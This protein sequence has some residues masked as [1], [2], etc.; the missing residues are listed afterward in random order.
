[1]FAKIQINLLRN[2]SYNAMRK[3]AQKFTQNPVLEFNNKT[4]GIVMP[5]IPASNQLVNTADTIHFEQP[6]RIVDFMDSMGFSSSE[7][8]N[9]LFENFSE[10]KKQNPYFEELAEEL[11]KIDPKQAQYKQGSLN[12]FLSTS[13]I[14]SIKNK[15][16]QIFKRKIEQADIQKNND[17]NAA[18]EIYAKVRSD[19]SNRK[20]ALT[21]DQ[22]RKRMANFEVA[23]GYILPDY[24]KYDKISSLAADIYD[25]KCKNITAEYDATTK[26]NELN[27]DNKKNEIE[28]FYKQKVKAAEEEYKSS[29]DNEVYILINSKYK[30]LEN[31][32]NIVLSQANTP[33]KFEVALRMLQEN[34]KS[35]TIIYDNDYFETVLPEITKE[36]IGIQ[37]FILDINANKDIESMVGSKTAGIVLKLADTSEKFEIA[38]YMLNINT[39][40][41][42]QLFKDT[43]FAGILPKITKQNKKSAKTILNFIGSLKINTSD[44]LSLY[45]NNF[46]KAKRQN[47]EFNNMLDLMT[48]INSKSRKITADL[49]D[50][51]FKLSTTPEKTK[52]ATEMLLMKPNNS[53]NL[54]AGDDFKN[55]LSKTKTIKQAK[56][57]KSAIKMLSKYYIH[58]EDKTEFVNEF[59]S[60]FP[61]KYK[62]LLGYLPIKIIDREY[63]DHRVMRNSSSYWKDTS[64]RFLDAYYDNTIDYPDYPDIG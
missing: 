4:F 61:K 33:E 16:E 51:L 52:I 29:Q 42:T 28:T 20:N 6:K 56:S 55:I 41:T 34:A 31:R 15:H 43:D 62:E 23:L 7:N 35:K 2:Q 38:R 53:L 40:F 37:K 5:K 49:A 9:A 8:R 48:E 12:D 32:A 58:I 11:I 57:Q 36:N 44:D 25:I 21:L 47:P 10:A 3:T 26:A 50:T 17:N 64:D 46:M 30:L 63:A 39:K 54:F 14:N 1:M 60:V 59:D 19:A 45:F 24:K 22:I 18:Y 27:Y 13:E